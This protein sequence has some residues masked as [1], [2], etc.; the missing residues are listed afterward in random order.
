MS[1]TKPSL[2]FTLSLQHIMNHFPTFAL[3]LAAIPGNNH[4]GFAPA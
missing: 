1:S 2:L 3:G 4:Y